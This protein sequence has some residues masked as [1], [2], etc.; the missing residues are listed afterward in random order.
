[1]STATESGQAAAGVP[2]GT[3]G[4]GA[5]TLSGALGEAEVARLR[6]DFPILA[7]QVADGAPLVYLDSGATSQRPRAVLDAEREFAERSYGAV[8]RGAHTL[9][10]EST[11]AYEGAR[12]A[13]AAFVGMPAEG[14]VWTRNA[15]EGINVLAFA[16]SDPA[17]G[18]YALGP[19]DEVV[20]TELEHHANLVPWQRA[21]A[22]TGATL[23]WIPVTD[24]GR[25]DLS[26]LDSVLTPRTKV[27]A[28][29]HGSNVLGTVNPVAELAARARE[30]GAVTVV[31]ACQTVPHL[32]VDF[33]AL[34]VD[35]AVFSGHKMLGPTG[36]GALV[37]RP[38]LLAA[39]PPV[40]TGG[41]M[42][43][44]VTMTAATFRDPPQRFEAGTPPVAQAVALHAAVDYLSAVGM[45]RIAAR[46][47]E[48]AERLLA[49]VGDVP[50]VRVLGPTDAADRLANVSFA[51]ED[52]HPHDVG[53]VLDASGI[54]VRVG[55]HC[56][57]PVHHR[58]GVTAS[59]RASAYLYTTAAEVDAFVDAL[60]GVRAYFGRA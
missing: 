56:A 18:R 46:E 58:F 39:L 43:E 27:L 44:T 48:L 23:R 26:A 50:G 38:E 22:R 52:V 49:G 12:E 30:V 45:D 31:D 25:L 8:H 40:V 59:T 6:A 11:D 35:A 37:A 19:G 36:I 9:A 47:H 53:Q 54:A 55:H 28:V 2:A 15:T 29:A 7:R 1:M 33:G 57:Q 17:A 16:M 4:P 13:V 32:P 5:P 14:L 21:C 24:A 60:G 10:E 41:S 3:A 42:V 34:G 20:V 51:V